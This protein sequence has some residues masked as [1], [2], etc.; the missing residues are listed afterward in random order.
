LDVSE[1]VIA[2]LKF[3][4]ISNIPSILKTLIVLKLT[5]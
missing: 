2:E 5:G 1:N 3:G 4:Q